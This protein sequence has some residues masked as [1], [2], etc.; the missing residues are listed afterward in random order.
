MSVSFRF[1]KPNSSK[2][3]LSEEAKRRIDEL[4]QDNEASLNHMERVLSW[5]SENSNTLK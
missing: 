1:F 2:L 4:S 3:M 5:R